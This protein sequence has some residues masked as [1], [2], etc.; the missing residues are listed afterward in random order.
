MSPEDMMP[1]WLRFKN[2]QNTAYSC[3]KYSSIQKVLLNGAFHALSQETAM[4]L[5]Q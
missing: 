5:R 3:L 2:Q 4:L 1:R